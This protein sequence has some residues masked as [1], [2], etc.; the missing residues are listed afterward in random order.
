MTRRV[1][2][3]IS[4]LLLCAFSRD[5]WGLDNLQKVC[6]LELPS[7]V[8]NIQRDIEKESG[9]SIVCKHE[10][11]NGETGEQIE[12]RGKVTDGVPTIIISHP[13]VVLVTHEIFHLKF[14]VSGL[15]PPGPPN[16][17]FPESCIYPEKL[18]SDLSDDLYSSMQ[19]R[20][21]FPK[22]RRL[23]LDPNAGFN[24]IWVPALK[25]QQVGSVIKANPKFGAVAYLRFAQTDKEYLKSFSKALVTNGM[26][27][28]VTIGK[29]MNSIVESDN[30]QNKK[31]AEQTENK[32]LKLL[33]CS[34]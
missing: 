19:H 14:Q 28:E 31:E 12:A 7:G 22:M 1:C 32:L 2:L 27:R 5:S 18:A 23:G 10:L 17:S 6:G 30:P 8:Q 34:Q 15:F 16:L 9:H 33:L 29:E 11:L 21:F 4:L 20:L 24:E 3:K 26:S 13:T 25:A